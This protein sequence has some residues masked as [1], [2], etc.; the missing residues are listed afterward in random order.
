[1]DSQTFTFDH[2]KFGKIRVITINGETLFAGKDVA[3]ALGYKDTDKA[4]RDH[5]PVKFKRVITAKQFKQM[6]S[7][8]EPAISAGLQMAS[9][10]EPAKTHNVFSDEAMGGVQRLTFINEAGL[11]KLVLRSKLPAAEEFSDWVCEEVLPSI[12]KYGYYSLNAT[13][14]PAAKPAKAKKPKR[15]AG[16]LT[17]ASVYVS[18]MHNET[19]NYA[20]VKVGQSSDVEKRTKEV[21]RQY[22]LK[23][24][25]SYKTA[26]LPRNVA[27]LIEKTLKD[28]F[29]PFK[30]EK[31]F[32]TVEFEE[33]DRIIKALEKLFVDLSKI[34]NFEHD[35]KVL[36]IAEKILVESVNLLNDK[37]FISIADKKK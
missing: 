19:F 32:F 16:Q 10:Q 22:G 12:R 26:L 15:V 31:E 24:D 33:A 25:K 2:S 13:P 14:A 11:Y 18:L 1:M 3:A 34:Y 8:Q 37:R 20:V 9:N 30:V 5:I 28:I 6:A 27:L 17:P 29:A 7:N 4:L 23:R 21:A 35:D 36:K